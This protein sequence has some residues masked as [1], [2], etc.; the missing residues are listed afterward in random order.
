MIGRRQLFGVAAGSLT[1]INGLKPEEA[2]A[3]AAEAGKSAAGAGS[4]GLTRK[5][6]AGVA[7]RGRDGRLVRLATLDLE[8]EQDFT[9]GFRRLQNVSLRAAS[10][11]AFERLLE[12]EGIDQTAPISAEQLRRLVE[13]EPGVN[14]ASKTWLD[15]QY[16]MWKTLQMHFHQ[17]ADEYLAEME[18]TDNAGPGKLEFA[19]QLDIP[20]Y[21]RHEIHIQPGGYVGDPF[22]GHMYHYGTNSFY[23]GT[24]LGHNDQDEAH[25]SA[26]ARLPLPQDGKVRRILDMGCGIGQ[27]TVALKERF[28]DAEVWGIDVG[29]PM[30]RYGHMRANQL[31]VAANFSQR[32][33]ENTGF[34]D[35]HFDLVTSYLLHHEVPG[36]VTLKII[37][38]ARRITRPGGVYY[39]LDFG[40]GGKMMPPRQMY[41]R[42]W[43]HRWNNEPWSLEYHA[44]P[45][46]E[47]I[48]R[49]GFNIVANAQAVIRGYGIRHAVKA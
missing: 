2:L 10:Y 45:F 31:G 46:T 19:P 11:S 36:E 26:A 24:S 29:A 47:E 1:L 38:E 37:E 40:S 17:H 18:A 14:I 30:I 13:N 28:P 27:L 41:G 12:R 9:R 22:A 16:F 35:N 43:D 6:K 42:W 7:P 44:V 8:S 15:N 49:R 5:A 39:P 48:G 25:A 34:P 4:A 32:L 21:A 23:T 3:A 33:A 20:T